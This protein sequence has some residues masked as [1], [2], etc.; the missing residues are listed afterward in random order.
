MNGIFNQQDWIAKLYFSNRSRAVVVRSEHFAKIIK[1][2]CI[3]PIFGAVCCWCIG[4]LLHSAFVHS[5]GNCVQILLHLFSICSAFLFIMGIFTG[6]CMCVRAS[7]CVHC[8][9]S[10]EFFLRKG[11]KRPAFD[12]TECMLLFVTMRCT[13]AYARTECS[14]VQK[15]MTTHPC[16]HYVEWCGAV[17]LWMGFC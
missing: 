17:L 6:V 7:P 5:Y 14:Y 8:W 11:R 2:I 13:H 9:A 15:R 10:I 12:R 16:V 1:H 4:H 3:G